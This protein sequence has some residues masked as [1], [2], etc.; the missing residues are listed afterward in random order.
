M[1]RK[2]KVFFIG[3][4][5]GMLQW[6]NRAGLVVNPLDKEELAEAVELYEL[7]KRG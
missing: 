4:A 3:L 2:V 7:K 1:K 5:L 6:L